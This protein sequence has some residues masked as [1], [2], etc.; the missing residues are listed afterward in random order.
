VFT[1]SFHADSRRPNIW[2]TNADGSNPVK[3]TDVNSRFPVCSADEKWL[4]FLN[5]TANQVWRVP[6]DGSGKGEVVPGSLIPKT[7][8]ADGRPALSPDGKLLATMLVNALN[9]ESMKP[10]DKIAL[11]NLDSAAPPRLLN[12]DPRVA[13]PGVFSPDG[14][15]WTYAIRENGVDNVWLQPLDGSAGRKITNFNSDR[16]ADMQWSPDGK[17]LGLLRMHA[18]SDVVLLQEAKQ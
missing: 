2:R 12:A 3:L 8:N 1:W 4:Y 11:I 13:F 10:E 5:S 7:F 14:R 6:L 17:T 16:I 15:A 9:P 18:E